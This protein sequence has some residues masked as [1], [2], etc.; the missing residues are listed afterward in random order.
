MPMYYYNI[1]T[2]NQSVNIHHA[3]YILT[4][5]IFTKFLYTLKCIIILYR[6]D[7]HAN[8]IIV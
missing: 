5:G 1:T 7:S 8:S 4:S 3:L 6:Y 2:C